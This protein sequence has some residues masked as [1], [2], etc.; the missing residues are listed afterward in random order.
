MGGVYGLELDIDLRASRL[1][2]R[3][4]SGLRLRVSGF[5]VTNDRS[6]SGVAA[7]SGSGFRCLF[8]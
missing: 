8:C 1:M 2:I 4:F 7:V 5:R 3:G 6:G